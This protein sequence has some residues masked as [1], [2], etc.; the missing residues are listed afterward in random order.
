MR[1]RSVNVYHVDSTAT[2]T[3]SFVFCRIEADD[4]TVGWGEAYAIP[5]RE[6]GIAEFV[7]GLGRMLMTLADAS[8]H[9][10][11]DNVKGWY[12][13]GHLSIDLSCAASAI[14]VALWD[15]QGKRAGRPVCEL[16]GDVVRRSLPLYAN[17]DPMTDHR[18][19]IDRLAERCAAMRAR[20]FDAVK[21]YPMEYMPLEEATE[22]VR[23]VRAA[24]GDDTR[25]LLD[26]W[27]L[28]DAG[29]AVEAAR[30]FAPFRP[31]WF[32]E[33]VAGERIDAMAEVRRQIDIPVVTG[34]RQAGLHHFRAVLEGQA[35]DILN[36][37]IVGVGGILDM[38]EIAR[39]AATY[40][41]NVAPHNWNST[42]VGVAA[43]AHACAVMPNA[44]IGEYFPD[45]EPY[46]D[47][48]GATDLDLSG[49]AVT[50]GDAPG[51]GIR[52]NEEA[53]S[54]HLL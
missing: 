18:Q 42:I 49:G 39:L 7:R 34:E 5:R 26:A 11:R 3:K 48:F 45:Y 6:R 30:A 46:C 38:L 32:E 51:F 14:E 31:F 28:D 40:D 19:P 27:A 36:P 47:R 8:P 20:G 21:I 29:F 25:L 4:G 2:L 35:A 43:M 15:I 22:C 53:L 9:S 12:D 10:F 13:E 17:M 37:D 23:R 41:V 44:L 16:L 50:I 33:P 54:H 24:I 1:V 52:M